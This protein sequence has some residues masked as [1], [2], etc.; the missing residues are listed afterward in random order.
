MPGSPRSM[1]FSHLTVLYFSNL[2]LLLRETYEKQSSLPVSRVGE[3]K[4]YLYTASW[5][6]SWHLSMLK[7]TNQKL[8]ELISYSNNQ[9]SF[10]GCGLAF[11]INVPSFRHIKNRI[12][13]HGPIVE[14]SFHALQTPKLRDVRTESQ[15]SAL[16][17]FKK[18]QFIGDI[19]ISILRPFCVDVS[20]YCVVTL[21]YET[22]LYLTY[23]IIPLI[24]F[25]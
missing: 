3:H 10:P 21:F 24:T 13:A 19:S 16:S 5:L 22:C 1:N 12:A 11:F 20:V 17:S 4:L 8:T 9:T 25:V 14:H 2:I 18:M 7:L 23:I 15:F 6:V